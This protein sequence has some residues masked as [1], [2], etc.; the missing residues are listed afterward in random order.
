M[1]SRAG[2]VVLRDT[3][4]SVTDPLPRSNDDMI[5]KKL[6]SAWPAVSTRLR[7]MLQRRGVTCHDAEEAIQ[8]TAARAMSATVQFSDA[9]DLFRWASVV[10]WRVAIDARRRDTRVSDL[11]PP[12][13]AD[14][15]DV[16][17]AAEHRIVLSAVTDRFKELSERDQAVL[18]ASFDEQPA[19]NRRESVRV[20]VARH[21]ARDRL[22]GL[23]NGL[24][25]PVL[26]FVVRRRWRSAPLEAF[27]STAAPALACLAVTAGGIGGAS[28]VAH[29]QPRDP[30]PVSAVIA[31]PEVT[32]PPRPASSP[33]TEVADTAPVSEGPAQN[34][35]IALPGP[36]GQPTGIKSRP[37]Q[38]SDHLACVTLPSLAGP[39]TTCVDPPSAPGP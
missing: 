12:E 1:G 21:R 16:A 32:P 27:V 11:E 15:I 36:P 23:L 31:M 34:W 14:P 38:E 35:S 17:Q 37:R 5:T 26:A 10:S 9:D 18:L 4:G 13:R 25:A 20:A 28:G 22:R 24:A 2:Q 39:A 3:R 30:V 19:T 29:A 33:A 6:E 7:S 8:E